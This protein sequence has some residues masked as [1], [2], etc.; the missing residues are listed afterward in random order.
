MG[1]TYS[2]HIITKVPIFDATANGNWVIGN[3]TQGIA[4]ELGC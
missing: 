1:A 4:N 2:L 3:W